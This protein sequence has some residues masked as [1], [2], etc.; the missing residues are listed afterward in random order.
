MLGEIC[1]KKVKFDEAVNIGKR[2]L[3]FDPLNEH[4]H[5]F[6]MR[7]YL[8]SGERAKALNQYKKCEEILHRELQCDP[9]QE[10]QQLY[11][12]LLK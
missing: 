8:L 4:G 11:S 6:L 5:R 3:S 12:E 2:I 7:S 10:T 1:I 9:S